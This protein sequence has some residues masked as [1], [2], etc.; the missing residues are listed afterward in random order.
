MNLTEEEWR[1]KLT[2]EQYKVLRQKGTEA[3]FSGELLRNDAS[4]E[5]RCAACGNLIFKS[6][7][8]YESD[9]PSLAGWPSF[10]DP[11]NLEH[12]E[13]RED[14]SH[15]MNRTEVVDRMLPDV[16]ATQDAIQKN[17]AK[18]KYGTFK[19]GPYCSDTDR[20]HCFFS[21]FTITNQ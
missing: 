10:S 17:Q 15:G 6:D 12:V 16:F 1:Q 2:P 13:L 4:G 20:T 19:A 7:T 3:P 14:S 18:Y 11:M 21:I 5:Y 8:K 9:I